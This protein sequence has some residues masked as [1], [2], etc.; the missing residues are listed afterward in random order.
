M[1]AKGI[2]DLIQLALGTVFNITAPMLFVGLAIG[3][4]VSIIQAAT[5]I[6]EVTL[7]FIPK[8]I[9]VGLIM[10]MMGPWMYEELNTL[11]SEVAL[12][13]THVITGGL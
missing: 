12:H 8:M 2:G 5:Q 7:V 4:F 10:W 3:V 11:F 13:V 1:D 9:G 6:Q